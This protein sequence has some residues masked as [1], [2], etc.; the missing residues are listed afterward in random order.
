MKN[1]LLFSRIRYQLSQNF[2]LCGRRSC[3]RNLRLLFT[4]FFFFF[5]PFIWAGE[6]KRPYEMDWANRFEDEVPPLTNFESENWL[7]ETV[8]SE[9]SFEITNEQ[10]IWGDSVAKLTYRMFPD[11]EGNPSLTLRPEQPIKLTSDFDA[12]SLWVYGNNWAWVPVTTTPRVQIYLLFLDENGNEFGIE[13]G[14][15][16]WREWF[17]MFKRISE[18][19]QVRLHA[20]KARFSGIRVTGGKNTEDRVLFFDNLAIRKEVFQAL[21]FKPRAKRAFADPRQDQG[22]NTGEG[23][24]PFPTRPETILPENKVKDVR[25]TIS[26]DFQSGRTYFLKY[27][28]SDGSLTY[29]VSLPSP[30]EVIAVSSS[31]GNFQTPWSPISVR[32]NDSAPIF[33]MIGGGVA[34]LAHPQNPLGENWKVTKW[35]FI[36]SQL[37]KTESPSSHAEDNRVYFVPDSGSSS[38]YPKVET[39]WKAIAENP[40]APEFR[41]K[42]EPDEISAEICFSYS[43][44]EK[45]LILETES[46]SRRVANVAY[47]GLN[48]EKLENVKVFPIPYYSYSYSGPNRPRAICFRVPNCSEPLFIMGNTDWYVNNGSEIY[49]QSVLEK[50]QKLAFFNGGV[51]YRP[52]TDGQRNA[53]YERF[54]LTLSPDFEEILPT[55]PN[56]M[57]PWKSVTGPRHWRAHGSTVHEND[58]KY[59]FNVHRHGMTEVVVTDHE[60][61]FRDGGESFTFRTK[62]APGKG[63]DASLR[64]YSDFMNRELGFVYGPY[65]NFTDFA[66]VN[67]YWNTDMPSRTCENQLQ[68][69]WAR[70]YAPKPSWAVEYCEKLSPI[71]QEKFNFRTA[72]CDVHTAVSASSRVDYDYRV[73]GAGTQA[74]TFYSFGEIMLLQKKA[75]NGPVYSE[76]NFHFPYCGLTDGNYAQD[77]GYRPAENPWLVNLDLRKMHDLC[78]NFGMGNPGMFYPGKSEPKS[79]TPETRDVPADRFFCA[80]VAFGHPG[81]LAMEYGIRAAM[82]GYF[83]AQQLQARFTQVGADKILYCGPD[84]ELAEVSEAIS[85]GIIER[86]QVVVKYS[87]GTVICA[88]GSMTEPMRTNVDGHLIDLPPNGYSGWTAD[89]NVF[90]FSGLRNGKRCDYAESPEY[91]FI[92]GR[93]SVQRFARAIGSGCGVCRR[94][95]ENHWEIITLDNAQIGF[96]IPL[97]GAVSANSAA[98]PVSVKAIDFERKEIGPAEFFQSRGFT[99]VKPVPGAFSYVVEVSETA[100]VPEE[101]LISERCEAVPGETLQIQTPDGMKSFTIPENAELNQQLWFSHG[102]ER[103]D[104]RVCPLAHVSAKCEPSGD[105]TLHVQP[106]LKQYGKL[107]VTFSGER[108]EVVGEGDVTFT[109]PKPKGP[110]AEGATPEKPLIETFDFEITSGTL[111]QKISFTRS[112]FMD[113]EY[114]DCPVDELISQMQYPGK[115]SEFLRHGTGAQWYFGKSFDCGEIKKDGFFSHPPYLNGQGTVWSDMELDLAKISTK[116]LVFEASVG[117]KNGSDPGD[118][119]FFRL[120]VKD[121]A[122]KI[123]QVAE[124]HLLKHEWKTISAD[125]SSWKDQKITLRLET[126]PGKNTAG[127]WGI[128][129]EIYLRSLDKVPVFLVK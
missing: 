60:T 120:H 70:C 6:G 92:D 61:C 59:W 8:G 107:T 5:A 48:T 96:R 2:T 113:Y 63:G 14:Q 36:K 17:L 57:S 100:K 78:V 119:I 32:W 82:R 73:P 11:F 81:F 23:T 69:A 15:V 20:E 90:T 86:S 106:T 9:A 35:E 118:G 129:S 74:A 122:G 46:T 126:N 124:T 65:N 21:S 79:D 105:L 84:G 115:E 117:K 54:F 7:V 93:G 103:I 80:T 112:F 128:W 28:G 50:R 121:D 39:Y 94:M 18:E 40:K 89:K 67:E 109:L 25:H 10:K 85:S 33:P 22:L 83:N 13:L 71:N 102:T 114:W 16:N 3:S 77:Q 91:V 44:L 62:A 66:P 58:K 68:G 52:K 76:G 37:K 95:D 111:K 12:V 43:I 42:G 34:E 41:A 19:N 27:E 30:G 45:S 125:L 127:D 104:F 110:E 51:H 75:W 4:A 98:A 99:Y 123:A 108:K 26:A 49:G 47:G 64:A 56:P 97:A 116:A 55:L 72:Y 101:S 31:H 38:S 87:D 88:N 29:S 53:C 24:L 1:I